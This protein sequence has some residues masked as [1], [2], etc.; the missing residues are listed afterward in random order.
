MRLLCGLC[1]PDLKIIQ[2]GEKPDCRQAGFVFPLRLYFTAKRA[3]PGC[4]K[5]IIFDIFYFPEKHT[6]ET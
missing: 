1:L 2:A 4:T 5:L 3:K 6:D